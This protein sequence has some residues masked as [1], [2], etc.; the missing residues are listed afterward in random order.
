MSGGAFGLG[1]FALL[2]GAAMAALTLH[3]RLPER[4]R[5]QRTQDVIRLAV[6]MIVVMTSL[7]LGIFTGSVKDSFDAMDRSV[8]RLAAEVVVLD[9]ALHL[10]G[11]AAAEARARLHRYAE[12]TREDAW[13]SGGAP[14]RLENHAT[15]ELLNQVERAVLALPVADEAQRALETGAIRRLRGVER[16]RWSIIEG[17]GATLSAPLSHHP[18]LTILAGWL[19]LIF[20]ELRLQ[21]AAEPHRG[22][23]PA[24][25][26]CLIAAAMFLIIELDRPFHGLL[27]VS[28]EPLRLALEHMRR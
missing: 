25:L 4:Q 17:S 1:I 18:G 24:A 12:A 21:R 20:S 5:D 2:F 10:H 16:Q 3:P 8:R 22:R 14:V 27:A 23:H 7:L 19:T 28:D 26:H 13:P 15:G 11:P 9:R 6:G